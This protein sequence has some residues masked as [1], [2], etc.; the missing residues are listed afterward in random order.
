MT[1]GKFINACLL[2]IVIWYYKHV[3]RPSTIFLK[4]FLPLRKNKYLMLDFLY[5]S[6]MRIIFFTAKNFSNLPTTK[7]ASSSSGSAISE[8]ENFCSTRKLYKKFHWPVRLALNKK[9]IILR[10]RKRKRKL[11][12]KCLMVMG[13]W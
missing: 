8:E 9:R 11:M 6:T 13:I 1:F 3:L 12:Q 4:F 7:F 5:C 10:R 2:V